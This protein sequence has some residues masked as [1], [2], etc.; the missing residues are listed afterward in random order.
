MQCLPIS[1]TRFCMLREPLSI[2][3][4]TLYVPVKVGAGAGL[5]CFSVVLQSQVLLTVA[6]SVVEEL[7]IRLGEVGKVKGQKGTRNEE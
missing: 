2:Y 7:V 4:Y 5:D 3:I 6:A 1:A